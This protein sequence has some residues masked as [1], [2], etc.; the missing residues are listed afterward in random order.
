[1]QW[2]IYLGRTPHKNNYVF[3]I[4]ELLQIL[5]I[6][7]NTWICHI[8]TDLVL[9]KPSRSDYTLPATLT[10][11]YNCLRPTWSISSICCAHILRLTLGFKPQSSNKDWTHIAKQSVYIF[12]CFSM[13]NKDAF[14]KC[15]QT[16]DN[17]IFNLLWMFPLWILI[18]YAGHNMI[19]MYYMKTN[20][21]KQKQLKLTHFNRLRS[22][23]WHSP[24][25][26]FLFCIYA[27]HLS[28]DPSLECAPYSPL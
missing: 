1:M 10:A 26:Q 15:F 18:L 6:S 22:Y 7:T 5:D 28:Q 2:G 24:T 21:M 17:L 3:L 4:H 12:V 11:S 27:M 23:S 20:S 16:T 14:L 8:L 13:Y 25:P 9:Y 19:T